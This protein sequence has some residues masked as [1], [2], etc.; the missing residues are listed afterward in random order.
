MKSLS[1]IIKSTRVIESN[2]ISKDE[3]DAEIAIDD[4]LLEEARERYEEIIINANKK[5]NDIINSAY[6][7]SEEVLNDS[8]ERAQEIFK[9]FEVKG[10]DK[11][12]K[13]G[14]KEGYEL[15][16]EKG[17]KEGKKDSEGL[18]SEALDIK[19]YYIEKRNRLLKDLEEDI[20]Q[21]VISV[22]EKVLYEKVEEDEKLIIS[23]I[24][25]GID[26]L[27]ISEK[28]TIIVSQEDYDVVE[29]SRD[30]I[31]AKAS[32][33]DEIDIRI[34][35]DMVKGDCIL[36]TSKG[37]VDVSIHNQLEEIKDLLLTILS[38]EWYIWNRH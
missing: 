32:L 14:Y 22:Y 24:L 33:V 6:E 27:E 19:Q 25:N 26:N 5:S 21:L 12:H 4:A 11:G 9:D 34:N 3:K 23:L 2:I 38:N 20:I 1:N 8:Y 31:L 15:G 29:K 17:Y 16:Y 28:L 10:Y 30:I 37:N 18:I 36:E 13:N 35:S 7:K